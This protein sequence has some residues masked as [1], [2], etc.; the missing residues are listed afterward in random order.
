MH[1][2]QAIL[3][4]LRDQGGVA[5]E[6][7]YVGP[8]DI[9]RL[10]V[11]KGLLKQTNRSS[12]SAWVCDH[13]KRLVN[14]GYVTRATGCPG[15]NPVRY[16]ILDTG[17]ALLKQMENPVPAA[18]LRDRQIDDPGAGRDQGNGET[19]GVVALMGFWQ[20]TEEEAR[21]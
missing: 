11:S 19:I 8:S 3:T 7:Q 9:G 4:V 2:S 5:H 15:R 18:C 17:L 1:L 14:Q 16:A 12:P 13:L 20:G 6:R 21:E 10:I